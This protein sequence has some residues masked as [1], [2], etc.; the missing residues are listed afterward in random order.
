MQEHFQ[1]AHEGVKE[2]TCNDCGKSFGYQRSLYNHIKMV[3]ENIK[4]HKCELC[5][6][7]FYAF[8]D[9]RRH[10]DSVH[11]KK[12]DVWNRKGKSKRKLII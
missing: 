7:E 1:V 3:H 9:L 12:P 2:Y 11:L 5:E 4:N 6:K 8:C 10:I